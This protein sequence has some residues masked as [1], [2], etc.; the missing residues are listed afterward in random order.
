VRLRD[1]WYSRSVHL[2]HVYAVM[3]I[4]QSLCSDAWLLL[5]LLVVR[6]GRGAAT[7]AE[8]ELKR[9][10]QDATEPAP[11]SD[12]DDEVGGRVDDEQ[13]LADDVESHQVLLL[14]VLESVLEVTLRKR[15]LHMNN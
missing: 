13:Q 11:E 4:L 5:L 3:M 2:V 8:R 6:H 1:A 12:V 9:I 15:H 10:A 7:E 14:P